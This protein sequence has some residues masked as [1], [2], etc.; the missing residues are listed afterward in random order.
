MKENLCKN[1]K[2]QTR[3]KIN[4]IDMRKMSQRRKELKFRKIEYQKKKNE[5]LQMKDD[6]I[7]GMR[8]KKIEHSKLIESKRTLFDKQEERR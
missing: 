3:M 5:Q 4:S 6:I 8:Q 1:T 2:V 7:S